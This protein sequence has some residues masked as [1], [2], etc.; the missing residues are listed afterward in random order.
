MA[1]SIP[2]PW[3]RDYLVTVAE[4]YGG[5]LASVPPHTKGARAQIIKVS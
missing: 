3:I 1:Q 5:D 4:T 2:S